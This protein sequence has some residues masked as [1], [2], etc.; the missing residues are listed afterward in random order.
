[1]EQKI[2]N[3]VILVL[4]IIMLVSGVIFANDESDAA[5][6]VSVSSSASHGGGTF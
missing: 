1:M 3:I 5:S 6:P 4:T 2:F